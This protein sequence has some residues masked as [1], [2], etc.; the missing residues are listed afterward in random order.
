M[1]AIPFRRAALPRSFLQTYSRAASTLAMNSNI[2]G[3]IPN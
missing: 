2:V 3:E 1:F